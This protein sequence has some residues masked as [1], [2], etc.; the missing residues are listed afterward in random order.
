MSGF[1]KIGSPLKD[2][3]RK[4]KVWKWGEDQVI[5]F[6]QLKEKLCSAEVL[7]RPDPELPYILT[8]HWSQ[9]GMGAVLSQ[10]DSL[11]K[12]HPVCYDSR[13]CNPADFFLWEL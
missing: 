8:T 12:E 7:Q 6:A 13:T 1:S 10:V 2:L 5:A 11:G 9:K 3:L 4:G